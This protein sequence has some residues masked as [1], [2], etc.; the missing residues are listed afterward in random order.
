MNTISKKKNRL[1]ALDILKTLAILIVIS[2]HLVFTPLRPY[3][4]WSGGLAITIFLMVNGF[5]YS[6][7]LNTH[8]METFDQY[9][10]KHLPRHMRSVLWTYLAAFGFEVFYHSFLIT[11]LEPQW[12]WNVIPDDPEEA[13]RY[14]FR[15]REMA[16]V[17]FGG[18]LGP[19]A[20]YIPLIIMLALAFPVFYYPYKRH[21]FIILAVYI[22]VLQMPLPPETR[23]NLTRLGYAVLGTILYDLYDI[24]DCKPN[25]KWALAFGL[26]FC[27]GLLGLFNVIPLGTFR[28]WMAFGLMGLLLW[29]CQKLPPENSVG[30][31]ACAVVSLIGGATF[32]IYLAQ[33]IYCST[34]LPAYLGIFH[35]FNDYQHVGMAFLFGLAFWFV[36]SR[37]TGFLF[38]LLDKRAEKRQQA[39]AEKAAKETAKRASK[40]PPKKSPKKN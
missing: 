36:D 20:Y 3:F 34:R 30:G 21:P 22:V 19:G 35:G 40:K 39:L 5:T 31:A 2:V 18:G 26:I 7:S 33:K 23:T 32:H 16:G 17:L 28:T 11:R 29:A 6:L 8:K 15:V 14:Y 4:S 25:R 12:V 37:V 24:V 10:S 9:Y 13:F 27:I 38:P 1:V